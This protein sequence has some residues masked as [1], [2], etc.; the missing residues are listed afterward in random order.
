MRM[1]S[2]NNDKTMKCIS[3]FIEIKSLIIFHLE[4]HCLHAVVCRENILEFIINM[5]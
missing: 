5:G 4:N 2:Y 1:L 3:I